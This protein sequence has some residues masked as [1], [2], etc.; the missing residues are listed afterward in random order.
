MSTLD[1]LIDSAI[2]FA[3]SVLVGKPEA[4]LMPVWLIQG[5]KRG[6]IVG[7]PFDGEVSKDMVADAIRQI[8]KD[9]NATSYSF[10]SEAWVAYEDAR[11]PLG[12]APSDRQDR[13]EVVFV[14]A[15]NHAGG[16]ARSWEIVRG[17]GGVVVELKA[18]SPYGLERLGGRFHNLFD[19]E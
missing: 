10:V 3:K 14:I 6:V 5:A 15:A 4:S 16:K 13:R 7:T 2:G 9:E 8:L 11:H 12:L 1:E 19:D 18:E 17:A